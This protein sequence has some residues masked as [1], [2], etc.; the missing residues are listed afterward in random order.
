MR[1]KREPALIYGVVG[2]VFAL[3]AAYGVGKDKLSLWE[4]L[5][6]A[7]IPVIQ[8]IFTRQEVMSMTTIHEAGLTATE[9]HTRANDPA[10]EPVREDDFTLSA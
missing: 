5:A 10:V 7:L 8:G 1:L 4:A 6:V 3:L 2:A 9:I